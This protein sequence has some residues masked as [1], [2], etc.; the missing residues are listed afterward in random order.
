MTKIQK[1][2]LALKKVCLNLAKQVVVDGE[3]AKKFLT[4]S[5]INAKSLG[6]AKRLLFRLQIHLC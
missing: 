2:E 3:G 4:I 5:V 1:F 6:S